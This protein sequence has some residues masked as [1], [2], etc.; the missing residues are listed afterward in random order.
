MKKGRKMQA[1][2]IQDTHA[3]AAVRAERA[4]RSR[5]HLAEAEREGA[6]FS[7]VQQML[8]FFFVMRE[9][10]ASPPGIDPAREQVQGGEKR[11]RDE[12]IAWVGKIHRALHALAVS[13]GTPERP[14]DANV[15]LLWSVH[16]CGEQTKIREL[17]RVDPLKRSRR[18][19]EAAYWD[20]I[21]WL[22]D[23]A[24]NRGWIRERV[25]RERRA[26]QTYRRGDA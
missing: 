9:H 11:D 5:R 12:T 21:E 18:R 2:V 3:A 8:G 24:G 7:N 4:E 17:Y 16:R 10:M 1:T 23:Y 26:E 19:A 14:V 20:A 6:R 22:E 13:D 15:F 25:R